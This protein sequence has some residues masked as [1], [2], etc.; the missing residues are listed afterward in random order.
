MNELKN[1]LMWRFIICLIIGGLVGWFLHSAFTNEFKI[2]N[3]CNALDERI[4]VELFNLTVINEFCQNAGFEQGFF[5]NKFGDDMAEVYCYNK[6]ETYKE[7]DLQIISQKT[8]EYSG[9]EYFRWLARND[10]N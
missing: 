1:F 4:V 3:T 9:I 5:I 2:N 10:T 8:K 7:G 6:E